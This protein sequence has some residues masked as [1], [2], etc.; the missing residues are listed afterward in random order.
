[1]RAGMQAYATLIVIMLQTTIFTC[2]RHSHKHTLTNGTATR[3]REDAKDGL[4]VSDSFLMGGGSN[5][6]SAVCVCARA[7]VC[8]CVCVCVCYVC[9]CVCVCVCVLCLCVCVC[10]CVLCLCVYL[11]ALARAC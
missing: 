11:C 2:E 6:F 1:M 5:S 3:E 8:V 7:Y 9:V 4:T 10:V